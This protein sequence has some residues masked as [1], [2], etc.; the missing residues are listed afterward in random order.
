M[1]QVFAM[2]QDVSCRESNIW[3]T[4]NTFDVMR[5]VFAMSQDVS[6]RESNIWLMANPAESNIWLMAVTTRPGKYRTIA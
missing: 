3:L 1:R 5:Q 6:C 4:A 2:S